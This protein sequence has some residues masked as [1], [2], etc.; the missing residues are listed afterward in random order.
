MYCSIKKTWHCTLQ[1]KQHFAMCIT[2]PCAVSY[3]HPLFHHKIR[4]CFS[5]PSNTAAFLAMLYGA[6][7]HD[8]P[9][10]CLWDPRPR[11]ATRWC[12]HRTVTSSR[13]LPA[14]HQ[15]QD[16]CRQEVTFRC[17]L[18]LLLHRHQWRR[19]NQRFT[20][21]VMHVQALWF[22]PLTSHTIGNHASIRKRTQLSSNNECLNF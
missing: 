12:H 5:V 3:S 14:R 2:L 18:T 4:P 13:T 6:R 17:C 9:Y 11:Q 19:P 10:Q 8:L 20:N 21:T 22:A 16:R 15:E 1:Y 7:P